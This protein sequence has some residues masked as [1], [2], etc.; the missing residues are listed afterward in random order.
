LGTGGDFE[1]DSLYYCT[2][3]KAKQ[4]LDCNKL[5]AC[6]DKC[7]PGGD[8]IADYCEGGWSNQHGQNLATGWWCGK[9]GGGPDAENLYYYRGGK[10]TDLGRCPG[11]CVGNQEGQDGQDRCGCSPKDIEQDQV[12]LKSYSNVE[13]TN[14]TIALEPENES[15]PAQPRS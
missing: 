6:H 4:Q 10:V 1:G 15:R 11:F 7:M 8:G 5:G 2:I 13:I 14:Y 3:D 12:G 9:K